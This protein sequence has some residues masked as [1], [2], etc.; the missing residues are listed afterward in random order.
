METT[1][2]PAELLFVSV[3]GTVHSVSA[4][5][6]Q[7]CCSIIDYQYLS[8]TWVWWLKWSRHWWG[9]W[10]KT[11]LSQIVPFFILFLLFFLASSLLPWPRYPSSSVIIKDPPIPRMHLEDTRRFLEELRAR[12]HCGFFN[13]WRHRLD[14][15]IDWISWSD[16]NR[17]DG[18]NCSCL[19]T[20][21]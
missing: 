15:L 8:V 2:L 7:G 10:K 6:P 9:T 20:H 21:S 13:W 17:D 18:I 1:L 12:K 16:G 11:G 19:F 3:S 14:D 4:R 5:T